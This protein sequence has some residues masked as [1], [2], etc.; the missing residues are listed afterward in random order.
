MK[1]S[2]ECDWLLCYTVRCS[3]LP[4]ILWSMLQS[5]YSAIWKWNCWLAL[6]ILLSFKQLLFFCLLQAS[7]LFYIS[8]VKP[9]IFFTFYL[10]FSCIFKLPPPCIFLFS[11]RLLHNKL[12]KI[13]SLFSK[14]IAYFCK[15]ICTFKKYH[16]WGKFVLTVSGKK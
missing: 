10:F 4:K 12:L 3:T 2:H 7:Q 14:I 6:Q 16:P 1:L 15:Q 11:L 13:F 5:I 8:Y 9:S